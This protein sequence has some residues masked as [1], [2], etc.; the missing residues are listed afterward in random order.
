MFKKKILINTYNK[1]YVFT[2]YNENHTL[3]NILK[4]IAC[5]NPFIEHVSYIV[6]HP[7]QNMF[8]IK[9]NSKIHQEIECL[10]LCLKNSNEIGILTDNLFCIKAEIRAKMLKYKVLQS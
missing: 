10:L 6:P 8:K 5:K 3:G 9:M 1:D 7:S 2:F 4:N